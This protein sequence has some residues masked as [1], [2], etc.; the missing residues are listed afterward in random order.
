MPRRL[1]IQSQHWRD[2]SRVGRGWWLQIVVCLLLSSES[3]PQLCNISRR[4]LESQNF[5]LGC[6][7]F[8]FFLINISQ[9]LKLLFIISCTESVSSRTVISICREESGWSGVGRSQSTWPTLWGA[10][11]IG[12]LIHWLVKAGVKNVQEQENSL[13][14]PLSRFYDDSSWELNHL[15][16]LNS[17]YSRV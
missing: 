5:F 16:R 14:S 4:F 8:F 6:S 11:G 3:A 15:H 17:S 9:L 2:N 10:D 7:K 12:H 13:S 1:A